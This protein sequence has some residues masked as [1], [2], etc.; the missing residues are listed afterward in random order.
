MEEL[1]EANEFE[2]SS[3]KPAPFILPLPCLALT[4]CPALTALAEEPT[5]SL[6]FL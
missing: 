3:R 1:K 6:M 4:Y 5:P 2:R